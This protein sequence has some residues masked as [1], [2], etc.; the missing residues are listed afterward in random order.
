VIL[1]K[2]SKKFIAPPGSPGGFHD[3][4]RQKKRPNKNMKK[5]HKT[6]QIIKLAGLNLSRPNQ[7]TRTWSA[8]VNLGTVINTATTISTAAI[9]K[10]SPESLL[11]F[12]RP[13]GLRSRRTLGFSTRER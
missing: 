10:D 8:P 13:G 9:S 1:R 5:D 6:R 7:N 12:E 4:N 2:I 3:K 11:S